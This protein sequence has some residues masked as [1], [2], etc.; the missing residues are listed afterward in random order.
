MSA[1]SESECELCEAARFTHWYSADD[2]CWVADCDACSTPMVVWNSHGVEPSAEQ[3]DHMV[4]MLEDAATARFGSGEFTIDRHMRQMPWHFHAHARHP[5]WL[6]RRWT[7]PVSRYTGV[8][9]TRSTAS[10]LT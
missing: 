8:G 7:E 3:I 6:T 1:K 9:G 4:T 10:T 2:T 5:E